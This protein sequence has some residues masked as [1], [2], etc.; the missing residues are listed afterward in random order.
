[1]LENT[2]IPEFLERLQNVCMLEDTGFPKFWSISR[3]SVGP[4]IP[5]PEFL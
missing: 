4:K 5:N 2:N 3:I 1:M